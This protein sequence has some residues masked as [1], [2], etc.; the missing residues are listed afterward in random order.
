MVLGTKERRHL[1]P[2]YITVELY[3]N[4]WSIVGLKSHWADVAKAHLTLGME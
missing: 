3:S 2:P 4:H 1:L